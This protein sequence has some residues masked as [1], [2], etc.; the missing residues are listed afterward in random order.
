M[1]GAGAIAQ[2]VG[3]YFGY[4][5]SKG[6][7][8]AQKEAAAA[9][10]RIAEFEKQ[11]EAQKFKAMTLDANRRSMESIR[12]GMRARAMGLVA[13]T[14]QGAGG[15]SGLQGGY[16]SISGQMGTSLVGIA[17]NLEIGRNIFGLN[18]SISGEKI[19]IANAQ[20]KMAEYGSQAA[21]GQGISS[22]GS[23]LMNAAPSM[24]R[25]VGNFKGGP[26]PVGV[27][28]YNYTQGGF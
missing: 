8:E 9:N 20:A 14:S 2:G 1:M 12:A 26:A 18:T 16:G 23:S 5:A 4:E 21:L 28:A 24:G 11:I 27:G 15:G 7:A 10:A 6:Q 17:Q 22:F 25:L 19:N 13:A 3:S